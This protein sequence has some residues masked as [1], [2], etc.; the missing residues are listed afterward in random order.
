MDFKFDKSYPPE[1]AHLEDFIARANLQLK[2]MDRV[3]Y[4]VADIMKEVPFSWQRSAEDIKK[5]YRRARALSYLEDKRSAYRREILEMVSKEMAGA[6]PKVALWVR[7]S[8]SFQLDGFDERTRRH[9]SQHVD[10]PTEKLY[11]LF[12]ELPSIR[13]EETIEKVPERLKD[14]ITESL[15]K[16]DEL[17]KMMKYFKKRRQNNQHRR[18]GHRH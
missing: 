13:E 18:G 6:D 17:M 10:F 12:T 11:K 3:I 9:H 16:A 1:Y 2:K 5:N 7:Q 4:R 14:G 8:C 15:A